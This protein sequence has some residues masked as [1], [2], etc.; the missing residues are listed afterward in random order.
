MVCLKKVSQLQKAFKI[1]HWLPISNPFTFLDE[2]NETQEIEV[3][4]LRPNNY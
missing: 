4:Y 2:E 3:T 1:H